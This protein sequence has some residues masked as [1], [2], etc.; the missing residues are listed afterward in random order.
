MLLVFS[1]LVLTPPI[2]ASP[3]DHAAWGAN[4]YNL[5]ALGAAWIVADWLATRRRLV[6]NQQGAKPASA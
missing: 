4:A 6:Q 1:V 5:T 3:P 2:F